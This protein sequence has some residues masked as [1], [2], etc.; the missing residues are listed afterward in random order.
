MTD[1]L[2]HI[3]DGN[4]PKRCVIIWKTKHPWPT[5]RPED[6]V[7]RKHE[8]QGGDREAE[9]ARECNEILLDEHYDFV[10]KMKMELAEAGPASKNWWSKVRELMNRNERVSNIQAL[11]DGSIWLLYAGDKANL[12]ASCFESKNVM[13][14]QEAN[15]YLKVGDAHA[16]LLRYSNR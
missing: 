14:G 8:A 15:K 4:I 13:A 5:T 7:R 10:R 12:F 16:F 6:A 1:K 3:V 9:A 2:L 11:K